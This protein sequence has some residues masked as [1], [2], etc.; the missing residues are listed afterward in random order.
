MLTWGVMPLHSQAMRTTET[1]VNN[2]ITL[3]AQ[4]GLIQNGDRVVLT[5]GVAN[6]IPGATNLMTVE[7]VKHQ[8]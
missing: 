5:A 2:S 3:A 7:Q 4:A 6:N 8:G 1:M